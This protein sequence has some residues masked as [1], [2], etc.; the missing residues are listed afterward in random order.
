MADL[1]LEQLMQHTQNGDKEAYKKLLSA[2]LPIIRHIVNQKITDKTQ[3]EDVVQEVLISL[4][5]AKHTYDPKQPFKPWLYA[6]ARFRTIDALRKIYT[7]KNNIFSEDLHTELIDY[8]KNVT[9][10][11]ENNEL[12]SKMLGEL[13]EKQRNILLLMKV[14]GLTAAEVALKMDMSVSAVKVSAHRAM[15]NLKE[16]WGDDHAS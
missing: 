13:P 9:E 10:Q 12:I 5:Q 1:P 15:K 16:K 4:H 2:C 11:A 14:E 8:K 3:A 7:A 6:I